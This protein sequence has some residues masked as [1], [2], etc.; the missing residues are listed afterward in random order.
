M[1]SHSALEVCVTFL[2]ANHTT[3][4]KVET[5]CVF[6]KLTKEQVCFKAEMIL[7]KGNTTLK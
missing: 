6:E 7:C 1:T 4:G 5:A 3:G 2:T